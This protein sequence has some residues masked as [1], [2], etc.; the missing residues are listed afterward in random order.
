MLFLIKENRGFVLIDLLDPSSA[1]LLIVRV[2]LKSKKHNPILY[3]VV[4]MI[5]SAF[6]I[7]INAVDEFGHWPDIKG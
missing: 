2:N 7:S 6:A 5:I 3:F 4:C 1:K